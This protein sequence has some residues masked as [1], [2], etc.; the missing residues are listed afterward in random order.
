MTG[1]SIDHH[2]KD[3]ILHQLRT[4]EAELRDTTDIGFDST[5]TNSYEGEWWKKNAPPQELTL[6]TAEEPI[7]LEAVV[8][9][10]SDVVESNTIARKEKEKE[11]A[12]SKN[13]SEV[14]LELL[15]DAPEVVPTDAPEV[16]PD[17]AG[18]EVVEQAD[19]ALQPPVEASRLRRQSLLSICDSRRNSVAASVCSKSSSERK[20]SVSYNRAKQRSVDHGILTTSGMMYSPFFTMPIN[21]GG[22]P[23]VMD[24]PVSPVK[25]A[26]MKKWNGFKEARTAK[27]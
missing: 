5:L 18:L 6:L 12:L 17:Q 3:A 23:V 19:N 22:P 8:L 25:E 9:A 24:A 1:R 15:H 26:V 27:E 4:L 7:E 14:A 2:D 16:V 20:K 10:F 11:V 21:P 13:A